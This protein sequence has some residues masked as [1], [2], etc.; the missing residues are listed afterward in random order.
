MTK[1]NSSPSRALSV[2]AMVLAVAV[3]SG[4]ALAEGNGKSHGRPDA[5]RQELNDLIAAYSY[6][7]DSKD[8]V[9]WLGLFEDDATWSW[10]GPEGD[11]VLELN[12]TD[13]MRAFFEPRLVGLTQQGVQTR[14][15]QTN[16]VLT[17]F[18]G[19]VAKTRT[20]VLVSWQYESEAAPRLV[21]TG[22]YDDTF[23]R[24]RGEWKFKE[25]SIFVDHH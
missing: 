4:P 20:I 25:R 8:I 1:R 19:N 13:E 5:V 6:T 2:C 23:V 24:T 9:R 17:A 10:F 18:K 16:T 21:H 3:V 15:L 11:L 14:H 22:H 12:G 7:Y